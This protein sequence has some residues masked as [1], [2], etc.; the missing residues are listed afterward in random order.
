MDDKF[1]RLSVQR[2]RQ[3]EPISVRLRALAVCR[4]QSRA[5]WAHTPQQLHTGLGAQQADSHGRQLFATIAAIV[6]HALLACWRHA[7]R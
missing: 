6:S 1:K 5:R 4:V 3:H 7:L 2:A